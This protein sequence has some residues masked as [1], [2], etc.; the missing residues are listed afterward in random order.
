M[1][2][3][4]TT[5]G[6]REAPR[7]REGGGPAIG[8][9]DAVFGAVSRLVAPGG[10]PF[11]GMNVEALKALQGT[12]GNREV[13]RLVARM[14]APGAGG[15]LQRKPKDINTNNTIHL[16][17]GEVQEPEGERERVSVATPVNKVS[18]AGWAKPAV[19]LK[20]GHLYKREL[21]G[22][23]DYTN[24][25]PWHADIEKDYTDKFENVY[26]RGWKA[27]GKGKG[28]S[29]GAEEWTLNVQATFTETPASEVEQYLPTAAP[30]PGGK[31]DRHKGNGSSMS[32]GGRSTPSRRA[33]RRASRRL[34]I[35]ARSSSGPPTRQRRR[36]T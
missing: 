15:V 9:R 3:T 4:R 18:S 21:G 20:G 12:A 2:R 16:V 32:P 33:R 29:K 13:S 17:D 34:A 31:E 8:G 6:Q 28:K 23:D 26:S 7:K 36:T 19:D 22:K 27:N 5:Q 30:P 1:A 24:V 14:T 11:P 25:V 35:R 10:T